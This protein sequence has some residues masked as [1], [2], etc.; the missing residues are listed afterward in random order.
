[1]RRL[2]LLVVA[3][4]VAACGG[5]DGDGAADAAAFVPTEVADDCLLRLHGKGG[6]GAAPRVD[7]DVLVISPRGNA[8]GWDAFQWDYRTEGGFADARGIVLN[9]VNRAQCQRVVVHG[10]SNGAAMAAA[11]ACDP[12]FR[13][14]PVVGYVIDDPVTDDVPVG[15]TP[16]PAADVALY[17]TGALPG[18]APAGSAC[19][20]VDW[21]CLGDTVRSIDEYARD[22][23]VDWQPSIRE[24]HRWYDDPPEI[25]AWLN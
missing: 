11:L 14:G 4:L 1:M 10:F 12:G 13:G 16:D 17:W 7:D 2:V 18:L 15:C 19:D 8:A 21:T 5:D 25:A 3:V 23:G 9:A 20:A 24:D 6:D 22:L